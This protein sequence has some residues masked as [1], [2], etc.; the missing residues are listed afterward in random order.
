MRHYTLP[1]EDLR[2]DT[3]RQQDYARRIARNLAVLCYDLGLEELDAVSR[4]QLMG[5]AQQTVREAV[6]EHALDTPT[7]P[8]AMQA[9]RDSQ[10]TP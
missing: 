9:Y 1:V 7:G 8:D 6:A 3:S 5:L 4:A 2:T 10:E